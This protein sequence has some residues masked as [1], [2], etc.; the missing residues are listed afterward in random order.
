MKIISTHPVY[1]GCLIHIYLHI[2]FYRISVV[3][4]AALIFGI[5][6]IRACIQKLKDRKRSRIVA[7]LIQN[8]ASYNNNIWNP[9]IVT[10]KS[11]YVWTIGILYFSLL[12]IFRAYILDHD[13]VFNRVCFDDLL[14]PF[15]ISFVWPLYFYITNSSLR[16]FFLE[17]FQ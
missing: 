14:P 17:S 5:Y 3:I 6:I 4:L 9:E 16:R 15:C 1:I 7:P 13:V 2:E 10:T 12:R 11:L 8:P